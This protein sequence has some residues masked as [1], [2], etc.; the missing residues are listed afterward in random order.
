MPRLELIYLLPHH[1]HQEFFPSFSSIHPPL[2]GFSGV[3]WVP[4]SNPMWRH[5]RT[6][7]ANVASSLGSYGLAGPRKNLFL[8]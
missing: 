6:A 2:M 4:W 8:Q 5:R 1:Y 3:G 7:G